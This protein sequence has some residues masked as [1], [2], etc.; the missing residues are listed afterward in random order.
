ML[1][2]SNE[3]HGFDDVHSSL[4]SDSLLLDWLR[5]HTL[6]RPRHGVSTNV[7][8][9][10]LPPVT[11]TLPPVTLPPVTVTLP[12]VTV[13]LPPVTVTLPPVTVTLPP[14]DGDAAADHNAPGDGNAPRSDCDVATSDLAA[15]HGNAAIADLAAHGRGERSCDDPDNRD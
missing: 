8:T 3:D 14:S 15:S 11:V 1:A 6:S 12:R 7:V 9:P 10:A 5:P 4:S 13:A 2:N